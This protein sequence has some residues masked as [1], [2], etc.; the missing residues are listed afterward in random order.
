M[1]SQ[2][3]DEAMFVSFQAGHQY[4][5][6]CGARTHHHLP[7]MQKG[8]LAMAQT[9]QVAERA[10]IYWSM[11]CHDAVQMKK[12]EAFPSCGQCKE[13][14]RWLFIRPFHNHPARAAIQSTHG[15]PKLTATWIWPLPRELSPQD[16][17]S[18]E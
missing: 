7:W 13:R 17:R 1:A 8:R 5:C 12:G 6:I 14:A 4:C 18:A 10:G 11:C 9:G 16:I 3:L 15:L 2:C